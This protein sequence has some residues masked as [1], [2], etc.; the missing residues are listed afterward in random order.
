[1]SGKIST[2]AVLALVLVGGLVGVATAQTVALPQ[3]ET[4]AV[5]NDTEALRASAENITGDETLDVEIYGI[6]T[7]GNETDSPLDTGELN[8]SAADVT[9]DTYRYEDLDPQTYPEYKVTVNGDGAE[10]VEIEKLE[11]FGGGGGLLPSDGFGNV[12]Q[13]T[14]MAA[15]IVLLALLVG[16]LVVLGR[17]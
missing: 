4:F 5:G 3:E 13:T 10:W 11:S 7:D 8:T 16:G 17:D 2:L 15:G 1:M 12:G 9:A 6:D 14:M